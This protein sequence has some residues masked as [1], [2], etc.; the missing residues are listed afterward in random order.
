MKRGGDGFP[1][2][3]SLVRHLCEL[4]SRVYW[5]SKDLDGNLFPVPFDREVESD[6]RFAAWSLVRHLRETRWGW[7]SLPLSLVRH[8]CELI[9]AA[10]RATSSKR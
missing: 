4:T 8:L 3:W 6:G 5:G 10:G 2:L 7:L 9:F 1:F